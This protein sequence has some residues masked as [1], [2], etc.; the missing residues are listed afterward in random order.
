M[1]SGRRRRGTVW[2]SRTCSL[3]QGGCL[4]IQVKRPWARTRDPLLRKIRFRDSY[5]AKPNSAIS[6]GNGPLSPEA[7]TLKLQTTILRGFP[8]AP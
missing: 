3:R 5:L 7:V 4:I 6:P 1:R 8:D 2:A